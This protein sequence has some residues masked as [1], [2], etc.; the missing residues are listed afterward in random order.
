MDFIASHPSD[1]NIKTFLATYMLTTPDD[2]LKISMTTEQTP[3]ADE[4]LETRL[5]DLEI[6]FG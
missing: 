4:S 5:E 6:S 2:N 1:Q 3:S